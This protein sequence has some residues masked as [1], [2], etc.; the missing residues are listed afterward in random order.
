M[1]DLARA[2]TTASSGR[3]EPRGNNTLP[4]FA[5]DPLH[6]VSDTLVAA[7]YFAS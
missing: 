7:E 1:P 4:P 6:V 2:A 3:G 5:A